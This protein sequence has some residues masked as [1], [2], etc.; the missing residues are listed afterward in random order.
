MRIKS[1]AEHEAAG[2]V[3]MEYNRLLEKF[4]MVPNVTR[5]FSIWPEVFELHNELYQRVMVDR[6]LLPKPIKQLIA[7]RVARAASCTYSSFWQTRFLNLLGV[8]QEIIDAVSGELREAPVDAKTMSLLEFADHIARNSAT[9]TS[10]EIS[11]LRSC[12][13][14]DLQAQND[15]A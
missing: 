10:T 2:P 11:H 1:I 7:L 8:N 6:T 12:G 9:V 13:F 14:S 3:K 4:G 5:A 15:V